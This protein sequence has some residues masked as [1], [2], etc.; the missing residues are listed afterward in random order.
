MKELEEANCEIR[1]IVKL[2]F[3]VSNWLRNLNYG[4]STNL[5]EHD[6]SDCRGGFLHNAT[7][8]WLSYGCHLTV[9][10]V[11]VGESVSSWTFR[12]VVTSVSQ[13]P[14]R[15]GEFPLLLIGVDNCA[16]KLK[17]SSGLLCIFDCTTSRVLRAIRM[18]CGIEQVCVVAGGAEWEEFN[19]KRPDNVLSE[20]D[21]MA[22]VALRNLRHIMID[23][24]RTVWDTHDSSVVM[25]ETSPAEIDF[26]PMKQIIGRRQSI[27][28]KHAA[29]NLLNNRIEKHIGFN[30]EDFESCPLLGESLTT[31]II[32]STKI[33]CLISGC[34]GRVIIWQNDGSIGWIST[35]IDEN[36]TI[37]H[38]A[39]LEPTDDPRPF[40]YLWVVF[41]DDVSKAP[42]ILR[43]YAMQFE[44]KYCDREINLY[45]SLEDDPS[46]KFESELNEGDKVVGLCSVE[47]ESNSEQTESV[48][49]RGEDNLLLIATNDRVYLFDLNQWYKEQMPHTIGEC[50]NPNSILAT[51]R[52]RTDAKSE[53]DGHVISFTY[54]S[55]SLQEFSNNGPSSPEELFYPNSLSLEWVELNS[56]KLTFWMTRGIQTDLLREIATAGPVV[57]IQPFETFHRCLSVG[58][59][60][61]NSEF[62]FASDQNAQREMLLSLC[63]EQRWSTF[64]IKCA[65]EWSDGS[66]SYLYPTFLKWAVQRASTIKILADRLCISLFDQSGNSIGEADVKTLRFCS[67][68]LECLSNV[69][70]KLPS[71]AVDLTKQQRTLRRVSTYFQVLLW[72]YDVGLLPETQDLEEE[73]NEKK[74]AAATE[75]E[76]EAEG[77]AEEEEKQEGEEEEKVALPISLALRVPYPYVKLSMLYK[78]K[79]AQ[80]LN[81]SDS[82][83]KNEQDLFIDELITRECY[84]LKAQWEREGG[85]VTRGCYPPPSLQSL[86]R[87]YLTD[88]HQTEANEISCRHQIT[89]YLLMDLAMLLQRLYPA[90][91][92]LIKYPS[93]FMMS[94]S[95]IKLTQAFWLLDHE[96]Y[97][98]FLDT[99]TGQLV[100]DS[101]IEDWHHRLI[102]RTLV[103]NNQHKLALVYLRVR[104]PPLSSIEEQGMA[105]SL[106][107]EHGLLQSA[108]HRRPPCHYEQLL[109][110]FFRACRRYNKLDEILHLVLDS[111]EEEVL[112]K[113]LEENKMEDLRVLYY[114]QRCRY[115]E[116]IDGSYPIRQYQSN[117]VK[118][119]QSTTSSILGAYEMTVPDVAKQFSM[120]AAMT[121]SDVDLKARY[122]RP[123]SHRKSHDRSR[124]IY[125]TAIAKARET[126]VRGEKC[127]IPF[128]SAP[129]TSLRLNNYGVNMNCVSFPTL[130]R[131]SRGKRTVDQIYKEDEEDDMSEGI[132][133]RKLSDGNVSPSKRVSRESGVLGFRETFE[134]PLVKRKPNIST[135]KD[136]VPETP[137]SILKIRQLVRSSTSP[138]ATFQAKE[139]TD[140]LSER[141]RKVNRQIRF[142]I[143]QSKKALVYEEEEEKEKEKEAREQGEEE[144]QDESETD[145]PLEASW[146][147]ASND[148]LFS[149][150]ANKSAYCESA[151]LSDGS[152]TSGKISCYARP[153]PSL[154]TSALKS[155]VQMPQEFCAKKA[156][157]SSANLSAAISSTEEMTKQPF[158]SGTPRRDS[159]LLSASVYSTT[160]LSSDS[161]VDISCPRRSGRIS[162]SQRRSSMER[163][164]RDKFAISSTPLT[165]MIISQT[166]VSDKRAMEVDDVN[167]AYE[168]EEDF[169][170]LSESNRPEYVERSGCGG[171]DL[172]PGV[173]QR[174]ALDKVVESKMRQSRFNNGRIA[175]EDS[176]SLREKNY[177][178]P[179]LDESEKVAE[180]SPIV[181][182]ESDEE[183]LGFP[184]DEE[185]DNDEHEETFESLA[186][187]LMEDAQMHLDSQVSASCSFH[188][189]WN[190]EYEAEATCSVTKPNGLQE[191]QE[192]VRVMG[193]VDLTD[194]DSAN[195]RAVT[196]VVL[197]DEADNSSKEETHSMPI[198]H[199][200]RTAL[201][202]M[203]NI[204]DDESDSSSP[205]ETQEP[206]AKTGRYSN[207]QRPH[208]MRN[209]VQVEKNCESDEKNRKADRRESV[210]KRDLAETLPEPDVAV[211]DESKKMFSSYIKL[212]KVDSGRIEV[213]TEGTAEE[214]KLL[215]RETQSFSKKSERNQIQETAD[216][217][218]SVRTTR[219]R[220]AGSTAKDTLDTSSA[221][222]VESEK[223]T[224][225]RLR[226]ASSMTKDSPSRNTVEKSSLRLQ[227]ADAGKLARSRESIHETL[228]TLRLP[229]DRSLQEADLEKSSRS[230]RGSSAAKETRVS[231]PLGKLRGRRASSLAKDV[232][233]S[234]VTMDESVEPRGSENVDAPDA[235][236]SASARRG[237]RCTSVT[238]EMP[239]PAET[240]NS[241]SES[242]KDEQ[243]PV[244][245]STRLASFT[246]KELPADAPVGAAD[247]TERTLTSDDEEGENANKRSLR[248]AR[249]FSVSSDTDAAT[250]NRSL[251]SSTRDLDEDQR[252]KEPSAVKVKT[253]ANRKRG[254]SVPKEM[255]AQLVGSRR[256][257]SGS[258]MKETIPEVAEPPGEWEESERRPGP[259]ETGTSAAR[260]VEKIVGRLTTSARARSASVLS[261]P[262]ELE[263]I[264]SPSLRE[265]RSTRKKA[266]QSNARERRASSADVIRTE[267]KRRVRNVDATSRTV[268]SPIAE[269]FAEMSED[270][271]NLERDEKDGVADSEV[272]QSAPTP[273]RRAASV[274]TKETKKEGT[275][276]PRRG[277][278]RK[279]RVSQESSNLFSFSPPEKTDDV[280]LDEKDIGEVPNYVFSPPQTRSKNIS[281]NQ[282]RRKISSFIPSSYQGKQRLTIQ[283]PH[284]IVESGRYGRLVINTFGS[285]YRKRFVVSKRSKSTTD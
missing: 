112:V 57:L 72:F 179:V 139:A 168:V 108:F 252:S 114:L 90:V 144:E 150:N 250:T 65:T 146:K 3:P 166:S 55:Q 211:H 60:P 119:V 131:K 68:Q 273:K 190:P 160:V 56:T 188:E 265:T 247:W 165:K 249:K 13:F 91:K 159:S 42:P 47:R 138:T 75:A 45:F 133:R 4:Q 142:N 192:S 95:L 128:V 176:P 84:T 184:N 170:V 16:T 281:P 85:I 280:P 175:R 216:I 8:A 221:R 245:R 11:K 181:S 222:Q 9:F 116:V 279:T 154:R 202:D 53:G 27:R 274:T 118:D 167:N 158:V 227:S 39:L 69:V 223:V 173:E 70:G 96:N 110:S 49:R 206:K 99:I 198:V 232:L 152:S 122:S 125:E 278:P 34:L 26:S 130:L 213:S 240:K 67:Q 58:L 73:K 32:S 30:R 74:A 50:Q 261:V 141:E 177:E 282:H 104:K 251:R 183:L 63:L 242:V 71:A 46:L 182:D 255:T 113:F 31:A 35:P 54:I 193:D 207:L 21:G 94:P 29:Y 106:S 243:L 126:Y 180:S 241:D 276:K 199:S 196:P 195:S 44:R 20:M 226:R 127:Q 178:M 229:T 147:E 219:S 228:A 102:L 263:E 212:C 236:P 169:N 115:T 148:A 161:S 83:G 246:K 269:E 191:L 156:S 41:Q 89:I 258:V 208:V 62:S 277:R 15:S 259:D 51:Y 231:S 235:R 88:C 234:S 14:A 77:Q 285:R 76:A 137:Q 61:F 48:T 17:D 7:Y 172:A 204:T 200:E 100:C 187:I 98:E 253:I 1:R 283:K 18:P 105:M 164:G 257:R 136:R 162:P 103:R 28:E 254:S 224:R 214:R 215:G 244:R 66:A 256:R 123:M 12:G 10:N 225:S 24:R 271:A 87:S 201:Y 82:D 23:L 129:C 109:T 2:Q 267:M 174:D 149:P 209:K 233:M 132:K 155:S 268:V 272:A 210:P 97:Q 117:L 38:L 80:F 86:L 79:R 238:T 92:Q 203:S 134:T 81:N 120:R 157:G 151:V 145:V 260:N 52:T 186:T 135:S 25:D 40:Y 59:V 43:M 264:L 140:S 107:V 189:T 124:S 275:V 37:T 5:Q 19:D 248:R 230:R 270:R 163:D 239:R 237:R 78:E 153:R 93:A 121:N 217:S 64:L 185:R 218:G 220:R 171:N 111:E 284:G 266:M 101:D 197:D 33:G 262:E 194:D 143:N 36:M 6:V 205:G 22:C